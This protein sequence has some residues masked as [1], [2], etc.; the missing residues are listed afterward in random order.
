MSTHMFLN[1]Q[2]ARVT[3]ILIWNVSLLII[4]YITRVWE[5]TD[6]TLYIKGILGKTPELYDLGNLV[7]FNEVFMAFIG[8]HSRWRNTKTIPGRRGFSIGQA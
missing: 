3:Q 5:I 4:H 8:L 2:Y 6:Y 1:K 7:S